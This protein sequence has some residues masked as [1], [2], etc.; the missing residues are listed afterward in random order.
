M[1]CPLKLWLFFFLFLFRQNVHNHEICNGIWNKQ[2]VTIHSI[3]HYTDFLLKSLNKYY[4]IYIYHWCFSSR[5]EQVREEAAS[6][7]RCTMAGFNN[8]ST[9]GESLSLAQVWKVNVLPTILGADT[10]NLVLLWVF[11]AAEGFAEVR[12]KWTAASMFILMTEH[13]IQWERV[14]H[15]GVWRTIEELCGGLFRVGVS[16]IS[17]WLHTLELMGRALFNS[18]NIY[19]INICVGGIDQVPYPST[20]HLPLYKKSLLCL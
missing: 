14:T 1:N 18:S 15:W 7:N 2:Q 11:L 17:C 12:R 10:T 4:I 3:G 5:R 19:V 6:W 8:Q 20:R 16:C 9:A 13:V